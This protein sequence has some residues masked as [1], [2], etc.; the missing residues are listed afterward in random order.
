MQEQQAI[1]NRVRYKREIE[2]LKKNFNKTKCKI[3]KL[4]PTF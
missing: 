4:K 2:K 3:G 1:K